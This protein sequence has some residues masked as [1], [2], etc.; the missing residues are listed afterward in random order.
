MDMAFARQLEEMLEAQDAFN[1]AIDP[2]WHENP[3][4]RHATAVW[5]KCAEMMERLGHWRWW[6]Q[7]KP[8]RALRTRLVLGAVDIWRF[9]LSA[10]IGHWKNMLPMSPSSVSLMAY[11]LM[12]QMP[13]LSETNPKAVAARSYDKEKTRKAIEEIVAATISWKYNPMLGY[14]A[15]MGLLDGLEM[16]GKELCF[17]HAA[18][19]ALD[20]FRKD[21]GHEEGTYVKN[22]SIPGEDDE[23]FEDSDYLGRIQELLLESRRDQW[24]GFRPLV[25]DVRRE[26]EIRYKC[27]TDARADR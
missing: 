21:N 9:G 7:A 13:G 2:D 3:E 14:N 27:V 25:D 18:R 22:W 15:F 8:S 11:G 19:E 6:K 23:R 17:M 26:L 12:G 5:M 16:D 24:Y 4:H 1:G 10:Y 20:R